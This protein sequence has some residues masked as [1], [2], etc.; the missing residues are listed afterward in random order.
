VIVGGVAAHLYG[1]TRL[2]HD[3][4]LVV[5]LGDPHW[6]RVVDAI[7][8]LG[9]RPRIPE[10]LEQIRDPETIRT[11]IRDK[12]MLALSFRSPD[13]AVVVDLLVGQANRVEELMSRAT[14]IELGGGV[15]R[16]AAIDDLIA[17]KRLAGR[18]QDLLDIEILETLQRR[19]SA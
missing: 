18:P 16:I 14:E 17:M 1:S 15:V 13:G 11:W 5:S 4:D 3:L 19:S 9:G 12:H 10:S 2:T 6:P 8:S 7:W